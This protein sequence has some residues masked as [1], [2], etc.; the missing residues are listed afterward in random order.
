MNREKLTPAMKRQI[1]SDWASAL[2]SLV[3]WKPMWL[4]RRHGPI[5]Y[6]LCL[7]GAAQP[8][9]YI[10]TVFTHCLASPFPVISLTGS[11]P[12]PDRVGTSTKVRWMSHAEKF[13][14]M[15]QLLAQRHPPLQS[16]TL[17]VDDLLVHYRAYLRG[18]YG[19]NNQFMAAHFAAMALSAGLLGQREVAQRVI[20]RAA[21]IMQSWPSGVRTGLGTPAQWEQALRGEVNNSAALA[22]TTTTE[23]AKHKLDKLPDL[24]L[25]AF[26]SPLDSIDTQGT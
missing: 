16:G 24:G 2:P 6:G 10:P 3:V 23:V 13:G 12:V 1:T 11:A 22:A 17:G 5:L 25:G 19:R 20:D 14:A 26:A 15:A 4:V 7:D 9:A 21:A 18:D 8:D